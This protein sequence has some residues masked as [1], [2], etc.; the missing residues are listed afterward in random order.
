MLV[1]WFEVKNNIYACLEIGC[2]EARMMVCNIR[3]ERLYVLSQQSVV[4]TGIENGNVVNVNQIVEKLKLL[5]AN[6]EAD[7]KQDIQNVLLAVPSVECR[8]DNVANS[9]ELDP[10]QPI[11]HANIKQLFR[12]IINQPTYHDQVA[13]NIV[14]RAFVVDDKNA[15]QNPLGII[16][17]QLILHAQ[18][19]TASASLVYNLINI[20]ELAGF[21]I[22]DI[23][24]GSV[25]ETMYALT[26]EQLKKG[27]CHVNIGKDMT[28]ITVVHSGKV[29][30]SVSLSTGGQDVTQHI[31]DAFKVD[32]QTAEMLKLNFGRIY[33]ES[34]AP[35]IIY[36][37][38]LDGQFVC[39]TRQMLTDIITSRYEAILKVVKQYLIENCY[40]H[41][42]MQYIFT[43]GASEI[44]GFNLLAKAI[45]AQEVTVFTPSM[46]GAR[47]TKYVKLIGMATF[48][49]E[50]SLL[51]GQKS[52]I[53]DFDQYANVIADSPLSMV[54]SVPTEVTP[55]TK[56]HDRTFMD[57]KLENSGVLVRIFDM[58][59]D[60]K[61]E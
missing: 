36:A 49:H 59:F 20:A 30:S 43:G 32:E 41:D 11:S 19:V 61:V 15:I 9:L 42:Q 44:E 45:F 58:I 38:D 35:E 56:G 29:V 6:V 16:G 50:M 26:S 28:T 27:A 47:S 60:E 33:H 51:T 22:A 1:E 48:I 54:E 10:N 31:S 40:K 7:L 8:I 37:D 17:K 12:D 13:I 39:V 25:A 46:L 53:I 55:K 24:L 18:K 57:H 2:A 23:V 21:R 14:P 34:T 5:K 52:N 4:A 3:Q